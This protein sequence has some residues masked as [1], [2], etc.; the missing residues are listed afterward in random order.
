METTTPVPMQLIP[1]APCDL[2][3]PDQLRSKPLG[4]ENADAELAKQMRPPAS[5]RITCADAG[6]V[7]PRSSGKTG[8]AFG[9]RLDWTPDVEGQSE[10]TVSWP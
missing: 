2:A 8:D 6:T 5:W 9:S 3:D 10:A 1:H 4:D 7:P